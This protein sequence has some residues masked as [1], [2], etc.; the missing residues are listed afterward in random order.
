MVLLLGGLPY[1]SEVSVLS[2]ICLTCVSLPYLGSLLYLWEVSALPGGSAGQTIQEADT[3]PKDA[4]IQEGRTPGG[5]YENGG[6][7]PL[8]E[9]RPPE[10]RPAHEL[11]DACKN[12]TFSILRI[13]RVMRV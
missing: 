10:G 4:D 8:Q 2:G 6:Q 11:T 9:G 5:I 7:T 12:I 13:R 3:S 1:L